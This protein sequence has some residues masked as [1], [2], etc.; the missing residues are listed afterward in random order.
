MFATIASTM[1]SRA[2]PVGCGPGPWTKLE[3]R[4]TG[5]L[6]RVDPDLSWV[7]MD[8]PDV[9]TNGPALGPD[10]RT[11]YRTDTMG[12][13]VHA[14]DL[15]PDGTRANKRVFFRVAAP[16]GYPD[17]MT[18][19]GA[20]LVGIAHWG[21]WRLHRVS[22][23]GAVERVVRLPVAQVTSC[24]FGGARLDTLYIATAAI[25][26]GDGGASRAAFGRRAVCAGRRRPWPAGLRFRG[27]NAG[28]TPPGPL[29]GGGGARP[30][31]GSDATSTCR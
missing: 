3:Q 13:T 2:R 30:D 31:S 19:D 9:C 16:D 18:V 5:W 6:Y 20:G 12:G 4:P 21:G 25:G 14:F 1:A 28:D 22:P 8:G 10:G 29:M 27:V 11:L 26:L 15:G 24:A 23:Q 7:R 17:G